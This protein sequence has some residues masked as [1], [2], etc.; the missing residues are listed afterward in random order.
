[1][2]YITQCLNVS[3]TVLE[4]SFSLR[5]REWEVQGG[6]KM[7]SVCFQFW[8]W[9]WCCN[10]IAL[11]VTDGSMWCPYITVRSRGGNLCEWGRGGGRELKRDV[12]AWASS[13]RRCRSVSKDCHDGSQGINH[14]SSG[15]RPLVYRHDACDWYY[16]RYYASLLWWT[17]K[18]DLEIEIVCWLFSRCLSWCSVLFGIEILKFGEFYVNTTF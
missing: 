12:M 8:A 13:T 1:M 16:V 18:K 10:A 14:F 5:W 17:Q 11:P 9:R 3:L 7:Y 15:S 2:I 4:I 6:C